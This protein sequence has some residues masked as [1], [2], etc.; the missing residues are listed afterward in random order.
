MAFKNYSLYSLLNTLPN[1]KA[2][3]GNGRFFE[4]FTRPAAL[5]FLAHLQ[6]IAPWNPSTPCLQIE[7]LTLSLA[8]PFYTREH[9]CKPLVNHPQSVCHIIQAVTTWITLWTTK[10]PKLVSLYLCRGSLL[11]D[12]FSCAHLQSSRTDSGLSSPKR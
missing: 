4:I 9:R 3:L 6:C 12:H 7:M 8:L 1:Y 10:E 5:P 2:S 11:S